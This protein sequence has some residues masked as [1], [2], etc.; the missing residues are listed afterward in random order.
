[1]LTD[2]LFKT[3]EV[4]IYFTPGFL[5]SYDQHEFSGGSSATLNLIQMTQVLFQQPSHL[6][7]ILMGNSVHDVSFIVFKAFP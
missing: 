6:S 3:G 2:R 7:V 5:W 1:M 4:R